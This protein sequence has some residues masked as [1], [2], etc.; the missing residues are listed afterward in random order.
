M[1]S[2]SAYVCIEYL[3]LGSAA[4]LDHAVWML[5]IPVTSFTILREKISWIQWISITLSTIGSLLIFFGL[6]ET[7]RF[8]GDEPQMTKI[9]LRNTS[10]TMLHE[11][12]STNF[13][14]EK[15]NYL[16]GPSES[17]H[18]TTTVPKFVCGLILAFARGISGNLY[19]AMAKLLQDHLKSP[20]ILAVWYNLAGML[21]CAVLMLMLEFNDISLPSR[22]PVTG[23]TLL[24]M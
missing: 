9:S 24:S 22:M 2:F 7:F 17:H 15:G 21:I 1:F 6:V 5:M 19:T 18:M 4:A 14:D 12:R 3:P 16:L 11:N 20:V 8:N 13:S 10:T 23:S